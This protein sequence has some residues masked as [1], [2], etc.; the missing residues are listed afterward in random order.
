MIELTDLNILNIN[1]S[2]LEYRTIEAD[3]ETLHSMEAKLLVITEA[4]RQVQLIKKKI[5]R[6]QNELSAAIISIGKSLTNGKSTVDSQVTNNSITSTNLQPTSN[7]SRPTVQQ[8]P[9]VQLRPTVQQQPSVQSR[10]NIQQYAVRSIYSISEDPEETADIYDRTTTISER[11]DNTNRP[12]SVSKNKSPSHSKQ[13]GSDMLPSTIEY[14]EYFSAMDLIVGVKNKYKIRTERKLKIQDIPFK[15]NEFYATFEST[16]TFFMFEDKIWFRL[17]SGIF[18]EVPFPQTIEAYV[19]N[20]KKTTHCKY[21]YASNCPNRYAGCP[22][23]H[24]GENIV[25]VIDKNRYPIDYANIKAFDI[26]DIKKLLLY[27]ISDIFQIFLWFKHR[28][29]SKGHITQL[30]TY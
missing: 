17:S 22:F 6:Y 12:G 8:N 1:W 26:N 29:I 30:E 24:K 7:T 19:V 9:T 27:T 13:D 16:D 28:N 18:I 20:K 25:K 15:I 14:S 11:S 2:P 10:S 21:V 5:T 23:V 3:K 4:V